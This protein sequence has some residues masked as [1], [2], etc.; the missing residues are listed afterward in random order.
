MSRGETTAFNE[1]A[2]QSGDTFPDA[3]YVKVIVAPSSTA[4]TV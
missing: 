2:Y 1:G 3:G 4:F